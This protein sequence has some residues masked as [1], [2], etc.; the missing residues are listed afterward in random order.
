MEDSELYKKMGVHAK[1][2][3]ILG[4]KSEIS[5]NPNM[6]DFGIYEEELEELI[7]KSA[8]KA[9]KKL[10]DI[11]QITC[12][13]IIPVQIGQKDFRDFL[14]PMK[15][16]DKDLRRVTYKSLTTTFRIIEYQPKGTTKKID[17]R[18]RLE[19]IL[20]KGSELNLK[21]FKEGVFELK[22]GGYELNMYTP[23]KSD[24]TREQSKRLKI[25]NIPL[26]TIPG[27]LFSLLYKPERFKKIKKS[28][29]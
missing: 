24:S 2:W 18:Y 25:D 28:L 27:F 6:A 1:T 16:I 26:T 23:K 10:V 21:R 29:V 3:L 13:S 22:K 11:L 17:K 12:M 19:I 5:P 8:E 9:A 15:S 20:D 7:K 14:D 4:S